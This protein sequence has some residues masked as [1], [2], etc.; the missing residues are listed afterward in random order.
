MSEH[1]SGTVTFL[2]SDIE[3]ST[4]LLRR[5]GRDGYEHML[6]Q[7]DEI[8]REA[9]AASD[10]R[11]VDTQGDSFFAAF[12]AAR[13]AVLAAVEAQRGLA[14]AECPDGNSLK[15]RMGLHSG[16]PKASG[17]RY[18]GIG[19]HRAARVGGAA[20]GGQVLLSET[21]RALV[22]DDLPEGVSL[23]DLG[24]YR[25]KDIDRPERI[26]QLTAEGLPATFPPL[27]AQRVQRRP[28]LRGRSALA[29]ALVGV[30][31]AA[32][33]I[34]VFALSG[35]SGV[36]RASL[37][38]DTLGAFDSGG[39][40]VGHAAIGAEP[41]A[42]AAGS[43]DVWVAST[44]DNTV[45]RIDPKT[46]AQQPITVGNSPSAVTVGGGFVWVAN[47]L[48]GTV[49]KIAPG[50]NVPAD[51]IPV[52][53]GPAG[54]AVGARRLWVANSIDRTV[55][56]FRLGAH[57]PLKTFDLP[58][59][60]DGI[61]FGHGSAWVVGSTGNSVTQIVPGSSSPLPAIQVGNDPRAI[62]YGAGAVWVANSLDGTVSRID[63]GTGRVSSP[64]D[65]GI[66]PTQI[67]ASKDAVWVAD[68]RS[69]VVSRI[70]PTKRKA[71]PPVQIGSRGAAV[72]ATGSSLFVAAATTGRSHQGGTLRVTTEPF[73]FGIDPAK[74]DEATSWSAL[75]MT[76]DGLITYQRVGGSDGTRLVP[77][78]ATSIPSPSPDGKTYAFRVLG[79]IHYSNGA[80]VEPADFRRAIERTLALG[81]AGSGFFSDIVGA[82]ACTKTR[83]DLSRGIV[84]NQGA[85]TVTFRLRAPDPDFLFKLAA[86]WAYA[87]PAD[88]PLKPDRQLPA[89][90][91]YMIKHYR[92]GHG[93]VLVRNP[94]FRVWNPAA[95]PPGYP[96]KIQWSFVDPAKQ[97]AKAKAAVQAV[98]KRRSDYTDLAGGDMAALHREGYRSSVHVEPFFSTFYFVF[99]TRIAPFNNADARKAV[100]YAIDRRTASIAWG[101]SRPACQVLPP[102]L[103]GYARYCPY[104]AQP[105]LAR[106]QQL[107]AASG[108]TGQAVTLLAFSGSGKAARYLRSIL[109]QLGY[110]VR[111]HVYAFVPYFGK[112][113]PKSRSFQIATSGW[114][115]DFPSAYDFFQFTF[116]CREYPPRG[117]NFGRFCD[118]TIDRE[119]TR[120][121]LAQ[122][123]NPQRAAELWSKLDHQ[124]VDAAPWAAFGNGTRVDFVSS[125]VGG[126]QY[127]PWWGV[128][129]DQLW[130]R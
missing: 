111:L 95:Q 89:T 26:S 107:V 67:A 73:Q 130:V 41:S 48:D 91:P 106:A 100:N 88:W 1:S 44:G 12:R 127:N 79:G 69:G 16:E 45:T 85:R 96:D 110:R 72:A 49:S 59:G 51:T 116:A 4:A 25:L 13:D 102:N 86:S 52:G 58:G 35:S 31:A 61:A 20:H 70:D 8:L 38:P 18:V 90:G 98:R 103:V 5:L 128:L 54:V 122:N 114:L 108:T 36:A 42:L 27:R 92:K 84:I 57:K 80:L 10:G 66:N 126:Y 94:R 55:M 113:L 3:G 112:V 37:A 19:V 50:D 125:R 22:E 28:P 34:P 82:G 121:D 93:M 17:E 117:A 43:G 65:V 15:V 24:P 115:A 62:T 101:E 29:A 129:L 109:R 123:S 124:V 32:V 53:N 14:A 63:P 75:S 118:H 30:I 74:A 78:L 99:N 33:A 23:R 119:I 77:D 47:S 120:A 60:A 7:H 83:C 39:R 9:I 46:H 11:V 56:E 105:N 2:F 97:P 104:P 21:T 71:L 6:A 87:V 40:L 76:N 68:G 81:K 64:I